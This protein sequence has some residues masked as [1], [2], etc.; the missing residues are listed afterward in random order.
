MTIRLGMIIKCLSRTDCVHPD[1]CSDEVELGALVL[2]D[3][4]SLSVIFILVLI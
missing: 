4:Q 1:C 2:Y 3:Q